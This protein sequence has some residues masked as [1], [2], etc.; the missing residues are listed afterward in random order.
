MKAGKSTEKKKHLNRTK[1]KTES[2]IKFD[3]CRYWRCQRVCSRLAQMTT[4]FLALLLF[5]TR[6][7]VLFEEMQTDAIRIRTIQIIGT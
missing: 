3:C 4:L 1:R 7:K 5:V 2:Y 6:K